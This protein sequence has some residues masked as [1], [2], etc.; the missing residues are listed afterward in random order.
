MWLREGES[1][2]TAIVG[3]IDGV[4]AHCDQVSV[5][6]GGG[7]EGL[8]VAN[9][10]RWWTLTSSVWGLDHSLNCDNPGLSI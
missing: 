7:K 6:D 1:V 4:V 2:P 5:N 10:A 3:D 9:V 8:E